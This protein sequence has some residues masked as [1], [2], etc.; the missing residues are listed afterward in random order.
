MKKTILRIGCT[1]FLLQGLSFAEDHPPVLSH[2]K[3][4]GAF[5]WNSIA[6]ANYRE[7]Q[8]DELLSIEQL[9]IPEIHTTRSVQHPILLFSS[10][11]SRQIKLRIHREPY[12]TWARDMIHAAY[13]D[14]VNPTS[15]LLTEV[16]RSTIAKRDA[17]VYFLTGDIEFKKS[18]RKALISMR[19]PDPIHSIEGGKAG[20]G[21]GD[22]LQASDALMQYAVAYDLMYHFLSDMERNQIEVTLAGMTDQMARHIHWIPKNNHAIAIGVGIGT[23]ALIIPHTQSRRWLDAANHLL[24][25]GLH[26]IEPDGSC[27]EGAYYARFIAS[28]LYPFLTYLNNRT[29]M[30]LFEHK[31]IRRFNRWLV[32]MEKP[33]GS[34]VLFDDAFPENLLYQPFAVG[35]APEGPEM[36]YLFESNG[37]RYS[38]HDPFWID[39]FCAFDDRVHPKQPDYNNAI[40]YPD[41]G[42]AI[43]RGNK[44]IYGLMLA[45]PGQPHLSGHDHIEPGAFTLSAFGKDWLL[46]AGYAPGGSNDDNRIYY[47][48]NQAHNIPLVN[49]LG[50]LQNPFIGDDLSSRMSHHYEMPSLGFTSIDM[51]YQQSQIQRHLYFV[52][53]QY[54]VVYDK[55]QSDPSDR[56][57]IPWHGLGNYQQTGENGMTWYQ[58][59]QS[60]HAEFLTSQDRSLPIE[61][62]QALHTKSGKSG[63]HTAVQV[64]LPHSD[65]NQLLSLFIPMNTDMNQPPS[66]PIS[67]LSNTHA[68]A[69]KIILGEQD[70][71]SILILAE[72]DWKCEGFESDAEMGIIH[73]TDWSENIE[74]SMENATYLIMA[75]DTIFHSD[76]PVHLSMKTDTRGWFGYI[77]WNHH[78]FRD[79]AIQFYPSTDPGVIYLETRNQRYQWNGQTVQMT[80]KKSGR[81]EMGAMQTRI[82]K[83]E[84]YRQAYSM[85]HRTGQWQNNFRDLTHAEINQ[86]QN[87]GFHALG[88]TTLQ[89]SDSLLGTENGIS[90]IYKVLCGLGNHAYNQAGPDKMTLPHRIQLQ[91]GIF[92]HDVKYHEEGLYT[93]HGIDP[94]YQNITVDNKYTYQLQSQPWDQNSHQLFIRDNQYSL[95]A[96]LD[97]AENSKD[98]QLSFTKELEQGWWT[99]SHNSFSSDQNRTSYFS[100]G[101]GSWTGNMSYCFKEN[102]SDAI[103]IQTRYQT[104]QHSTALD[105]NYNEIQGWTKLS[106]HQTF[107]P[108]QQVFC[109]IHY[110]PYRDSQSNSWKTMAS[111]NFWMRSNKMNGLLSFYRNPNGTLLSQWRTT[112]QHGKWRMTQS[113]SY[114]DALHGNITIA[115]RNQYT[116]GEISLLDNQFLQARTVWRPELGL[117]NTFNMRWDSKSNQ[118]NMIGMG[119]YSHQQMHWGAEINY[120]HDEFRDGC[121]MTGTLGFPINDVESLQFFANLWID[122]QGALDTYQIQIMQFGR[123]RTPGILIEKDSRGLV[124]FEGYLLWYF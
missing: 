56:I 22:W 48:G 98:Y 54:F 38:K 118:W 86:I 28:R 97:D 37:Q 112:I 62:R 21:W 39:A 122:K 35:L 101:Q 17:F 51:Y 27:R 61:T 45:E 105:G 77:N 12:R 4:A 47:V 64:H 41:G 16:E 68:V 93:R 76:T 58:E 32:D 81:F 14:Y 11:Q 7:L 73:Q 123:F 26:M 82:H 52:G 40:F 30:N 88:K 5:L 67:I 49:G 20:F 111:S 75:G 71:K 96:S 113:G 10:G 23:V 102:N 80:L 107:Q 29:G 117:S 3:D 91:K 8:I 70:K 100:F 99:L 89:V 6:Q 57:T 60:L 42:Y 15:P 87:E 74:F 85:L 108:V 50:P 115:K 44:D 13:G 9:S 110:L 78:E 84:S 66:L 46:D 25:D 116:S 33:D 104:A 1:L 2:L 69:R 19:S 59:S 106:L 18:A 36:R 90:N 53:G 121:M 72:S 124:R 83:T 63:T 94:Q 55:V 31:R 34:M 119:F 103:N 79:S 120:H 114:T 95:S 24:K 109:D 65:E 92:G 43:F